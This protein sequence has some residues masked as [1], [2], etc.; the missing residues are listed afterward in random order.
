MTTIRRQILIPMLTIVVLSLAAV[1]WFAS[2]TLSTQAEQR[3]DE[4]L[5]A[6]AAEASAIL[7]RLLTE[8]ITQASSNAYSASALLA[9]NSGPFD[10]AGYAQTLLQQLPHRDGFAGL[11]VG[12]DPNADGQDAKYANTPYGDAQGRYLIYASRGANNAIALSVEPLTGAEAEKGW[13][14]RPIKEKQT[15]ITPPYLYEIQGKPVMM[16]TISSPIQGKNQNFVGVATADLSLAALTERVKALKVYD[17]GHAYV[18]AHDDTWVATPDSADRGKPVS[19]P[20]LQALIKQARQSGSV[21]QPLQDRKSGQEML[22]TAQAVSL[23]GVKETWI[24]LVMAPASEVMAE[25]NRTKTILLVVGLLAVVAGVA[26]SVWIGGRISAQMQTMTSCMTALA[27]GQTSV[28]IPQV[29]K[30]VELKAMSTALSIFQNNMDSNRRMAAEQQVAQQAQIERAERIRA[31]TASFDREVGQT[32]NAVEATAQKLEETAQ[33]M[34]SVAQATSDQAY[35]VVGAAEQSQAN[36]ETV[37]AA[38]E[39]LSAS[40]H[41]ISRHVQASSQIAREAVSIAEHSKTLVHSLAESSVKISEV[42]QLINDVANQTNLLALNATIEAAR[43]GEAGKGF[44]VVANEVKNLASQTSRATDEI[45]HQITAVQA[46]TRNAVEANQEIVNVIARI[47]EVAT[48]IASAVE[49]QGAAT[50]E[51]ARNIQQ[52]ASSTSEVTSHIGQMRQGAERTG[53]AASGLLAE[54]EQMAERAEMLRTEVD[55]F[56]RDISQA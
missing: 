38:A 29:E 46:A 3:A 24:T 39:E 36:V 55:G 30:P 8:A 41:E 14:D 34:T 18:I 52:A 43:A 4:T 23:P 56:L 49:E 37:A 40:I 13:Y 32:V 5:Q 21:I 22:V 31:M 16:A 51:I 20:A 25:A 2:Q 9:A 45:A 7:D 33:A 12:L 53:T 48:T 10:R 17:S 11:Y 27:D 50:N 19:D 47:D 42:V 54:A 1:I 26:L 44:A 6:K 15:I 28:Q 35:Q